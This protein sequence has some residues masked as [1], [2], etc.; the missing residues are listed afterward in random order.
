MSKMIRAFSFIHLSALL[1]SSFLLHHSFFL[2][3]IFHT[4]RTHTHR[5][6]LRLY[7][8]CLKNTVLPLPFMVKIQMNPVAT[9]RDILKRNY[10]EL[11]SEMCRFHIV[12]FLCSFRPQL[13][14]QRMLLLSFNRTCLFIS[15]IPHTIRFP[16]DSHTD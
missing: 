3:V 2:F 14:M 10:H 1:L 15:N 8:N 7:S 12:C 16:R 11:V 9:V 13:F 6:D 5:K 4:H